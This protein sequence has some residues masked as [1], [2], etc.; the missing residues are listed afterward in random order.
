[1][2]SGTYSDVVIVTAITILFLLLVALNSLRQN[3]VAGLL[4]LVSVN[5]A[6]W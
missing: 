5:V 1:M 6:K 2:F 4:A 3:C